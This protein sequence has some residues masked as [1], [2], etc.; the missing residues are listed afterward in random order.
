MIGKRTKERIPAEIHRD[1]L[2][3]IPS[4]NAI[5]HS[6]YFEIFFLNF[7]QSSS[8]LSPSSFLRPDTLS[9][10]Q[11]SN[12]RSGDAGSQQR[13]RKEDKQKPWPPTSLLRP[14]AAR[15]ASARAC[16]HREL[17]AQASIADEPFSSRRR[18]HA[19]PEFTTVAGRN[20][21]AILLP[22]KLHVSRVGYHVEQR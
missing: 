3:I 14:R 10:S 21:F 15:R 18:A 16:A 19:I 1:L 7:G 13:L 11:D 20:S 5:F 6:I 17:T 12:G 8:L 2:G 22:L 4:R 9:E